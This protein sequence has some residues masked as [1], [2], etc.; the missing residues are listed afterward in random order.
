MVFLLLS[1][2]SVGY[3]KDKVV[4]V[5]TCSDMFPEL[6]PLYFPL[7]SCII[8][9]LYGCLCVHMQMC[10]LVFHDMRK[11][12][13]CSN[14]GA[15]FSKVCLLNLQKTACSVVISQLQNTYITVHSLAYSFRM[16]SRGDFMMVFIP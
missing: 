4:N 6:G 2:C 11:K 10:V 16:L 15:L 14:L 12:D 9:S 5:G 3:C 13:Q 1:L 8:P 7:E